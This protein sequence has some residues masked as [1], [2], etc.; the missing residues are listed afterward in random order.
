MHIVLN[1]YKNLFSHVT[2]DDIDKL[3][4]RLSNLGDSIVVV[5]IWILLRFMYIPICLE[6]SSVSIEIW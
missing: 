4:G 1:F 3:K 6:G 5:G 2:E